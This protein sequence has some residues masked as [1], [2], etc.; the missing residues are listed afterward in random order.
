MQ[1]GAFNLFTALRT[2]LLQNSLN[3]SLK[4]TESISTIAS[5]VHETRITTYRT[6]DDDEGTSSGDR[7]FHALSKYLDQ[8]AH[9]VQRLHTKKE[10][11]LV[12]EEPVQETHAISSTKEINVDLDYVPS[13]HDI[14]SACAS[15]LEK[16]PHMTT[17]GSKKNKLTPNEEGANEKIL[18]NE[19]KRIPTS[20]R[21]FTLTI[22]RRHARRISKE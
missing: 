22:F 13:S 20:P 3:S 14:I 15:K 7:T 5:K 8:V 18:F 19:K 4:A 10:V 12:K 21:G 11:G 17:R 6:E 9:L 2:L 16:L 1:R